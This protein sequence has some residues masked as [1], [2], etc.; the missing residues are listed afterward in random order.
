MEFGGGFEMP[1]G[2]YGDNEDRIS[3]PPI[4]DDDE[5]EDQK[6][7]DAKERARV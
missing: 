7:Q 3:L 2:D 4:H 1:H 6:E 5:D